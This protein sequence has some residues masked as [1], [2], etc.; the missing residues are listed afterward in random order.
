MNEEIRKEYERYNNLVISL[1]GDWKIYFMRLSDE[2]EQVHNEEITTDF[3]QWF[4]KLKRKPNSITNNQENLEIL[5]NLLNWKNN[6]IVETIIEM[7]G[8]VKQIQEY[9]KGF[10]KNF[11]DI[12][13][14][15]HKSMSV[16][17]KSADFFREH[18]EKKR[19]F[20]S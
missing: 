17:K 5:G 13:K 18:P 9:Q 20:C 7:Q 6:P 11:A 14:G 4:D 8:V 16:L 2:V 3:N 12:A 1:F 19:C 10:A 15:M